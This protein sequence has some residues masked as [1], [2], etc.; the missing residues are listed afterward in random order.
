MVEW[1]FQ[2]SLQ[3]KETN[4]ER[5]LIE[6]GLYKKWLHTANM[7]YTKGVKPSLAQKSIKVL[8]TSSG[9]GRLTRSEECHV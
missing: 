8:L 6:K 9:P 4:R 7:A 5:G 1:E 3:K 2:F